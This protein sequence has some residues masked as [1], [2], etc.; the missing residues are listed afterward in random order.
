MARKKSMLD[1]ATQFER[2]AKTAVSERL[3]RAERAARRYTANMSQLTDSRINSDLRH[4]KTG[5]R[6]YSRSYYM[7]SRDEHL[8]KLAAQGVVAG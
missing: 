4:N 6:K 3:G 2:I 8:A 7:Q 1:V 5:M